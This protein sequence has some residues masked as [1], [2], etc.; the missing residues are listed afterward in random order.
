MGEEEEENFARG[1]TTTLQPGYGRCHEGDDYNSIPYSI[2]CSIAT[3]GAPCESSSP[4]SPLKFFS[5]ACCC[6]IKITVAPALPMICWRSSLFLHSLFHEARV[7]LPSNNYW[8]L[9]III[10][11]LFPAILL[12]FH[13]LFHCITN[14]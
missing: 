8:Y 9:L 6:Y 14:I 12:P 5:G 7:Y 3:V 2:N 11:F 1:T 13:Y 4:F 10:R